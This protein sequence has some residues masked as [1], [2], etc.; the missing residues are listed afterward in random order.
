MKKLFTGFA[1]IICSMIGP[2][3]IF[4]ATGFSTEMLL[5]KTQ[6]SNVSYPRIST[7][8]ENAIYVV[9]SDK[10][11]AG[12]TTIFFTRSLDGGVSFEERKEIGKNT[13]ADVYLTAPEIGVDSKGTL[14]VVYSRYDY[15]D[16]QFSLLLSKSEDNGVSFDNQTVYIKP[17]GGP[18]TEENYA[19]FGSDIKISDNGLY[20]AWSGNREIFLARSL[21]GGND[22]E[23]IEIA[24]EQSTDDNP[25][26]N[27]LKI[28]PSLAADLN[29]N[30]HVVWFESHLDEDTIQPLYD[31]YTAR[32]E[33]NQDRFSESRLI[34]KC[35]Y[36][37]PLM[38]A[39]SIVVTS[40]NILF[41]VWNKSE[42]SYAISS[43][44]GG[45]TFSEPFEI[46]FGRDAVVQNRTMVVDQNDVFHFLYLLGGNGRLS[47][48]KS[49]DLCNSFDKSLQIGSISA[50]ADMHLDEKEET[51]YVVWEDPQKSGVYFSKSGDNPPVDT[52]NSGS[53]GGG[54]GGGCFINCAFD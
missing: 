32:T 3:G 12:A 51:I 30:I 11:D 2:V 9:W 23:I 18:A 28:W 13:A 29:N 25:P 35:D 54:G 8:S 34:A 19:F 31:L 40:N 22:F 17:I 37:A 47:Y 36:W 39:P 24:D 6:P 7:G 42:S 27:V 49:S 33:N 38:L 20:Y 43:K 26:L 14:F 44:D 10:D 48:T 16:S 45:D 50:M 52:P 1:M 53:S 41:V 46:K 15:P 21:N 5:G 4:A